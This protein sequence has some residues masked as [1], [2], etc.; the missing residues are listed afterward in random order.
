MEPLPGNNRMG[1]AAL[2]LLERASP[3]VAEALAAM[4]SEAFSDGALSA[5]DK[6]L[7]AAAVQ[8]SFGREES[9][10]GHLRAARELGA[11]LWDVA[12]A[13]LP[14]VLAHGLGVWECM[15]GGAA[16]MAEYAEQKAR[17]R[18]AFDGSRV[19]A[20]D[21]PK[22]WADRQGL[23]EYYESHYGSVPDWVEALGEH[24]ADFLQG[25][26]RLRAVALSDGRLPRKLKEL[27]I[28][29]CHAA[30][31]FE[32][33]VAAHVAGARA[34]GAGDREVAEALIVA[35]MAS[36]IPAWLAFFG[37][38]GSHSGEGRSG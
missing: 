9:V 22:V 19:S 37:L 38:A 30:H 31:R 17:E 16:R 33:G 10:T 24:S 1:G 27:I 25:Y 14:A 34:A 11:E 5:R 28:V 15:I 6:H 32:K 20:G 29:A 3:E 7:M 13:A 26:T 35:V 8:A 4:W 2:A 23:R 21:S 36:G 12:E 18:R